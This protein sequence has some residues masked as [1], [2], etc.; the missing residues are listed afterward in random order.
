MTLTLAIGCCCARDESLV[1]VR[2][3]GDLPEAAERQC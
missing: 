1:L 3:G 2:M